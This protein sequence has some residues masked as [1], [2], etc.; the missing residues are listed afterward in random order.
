MEEIFVDT[1]R[2]SEAHERFQYLIDHS[3][4]SSRTKLCV[5]L[6]A[7]SQSGK[8]RVIQTFAQRLNTQELLQLRQIPIL[9]VTLHAETT[10]KGLAQDI[11][12]ALQEYGFETGAMRGSETEVWERV[13]RYLAAASVKLLVLDEIHH[14]KTASYAMARSVGECIKHALLKGPCPIVLSGIHS[15]EL[16]FRANEQLQQRAI[17]SIELRRFRPN[18]PNDLQLFMEFLAAYFVEM[19]NLKIAANATALIEGDVPACIL[20]VSHGIL[21]AACRLVMEAV[22]IMTLRGRNSLERSDLVQATD[23]AFVRSGLHG[24]NPFVMGLDPLG[25]DGRYDD[26]A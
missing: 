1:P 19:E 4:V 14:I 9:H 6:V 25:A 8:T 23:D 24:R 12:I 26:A 15:A 20:E 22:T 10:R 21:G 7:P 2:T 5:L 3:D 17:P 18:L 13:Y 16:P 11:L